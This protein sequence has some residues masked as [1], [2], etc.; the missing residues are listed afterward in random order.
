MTLI[1]IFFRLKNVVFIIFDDI[2]KVNETIIEFIWTFQ[3]NKKLTKQKPNNQ[4]WLLFAFE[5]IYRN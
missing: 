5:I 3:F 1:S 4:D 2:L